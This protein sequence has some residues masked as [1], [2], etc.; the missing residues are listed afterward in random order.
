M[1]T[2]DECRRLRDDTFVDQV[3]NLAETSSTS[4]YAIE[5][6][7]DE[8]CRKPLLVVAARQTAGRGRGTNRWW[9]DDGALTFS[10]LL[11]S[12]PQATGGLPV[13]L[14]LGVA[15]CNSVRTLTDDPEFGVKWPNDIY[16]AG[17]KVAGILIERPARAEGNL[18]VG[19]GLN[20]NNPMAHA[21]TEIAARATSLRETSGRTHKLPQVLTVILEHIERTIDSMTTRRNWLPDQ[22]NQLCLLKGTNVAVDAG[23]HSFEGLCQGV[24]QQGAL[25]VDT[26]SGRKKCISGDVRRITPTE[27]RPI[28]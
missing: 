17:R 28:L 12:I 26:P 27:V 23:R 9:S 11:D 25:V 18:V 16:H 8:D 20:V 19:I 7:L 10:L 13:S 15:L 14:A 4:D 2:P 3:E 22:W 21:P 5:R 6:A 1:L 24:D